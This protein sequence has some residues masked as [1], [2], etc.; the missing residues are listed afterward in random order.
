MRLM[1][2]SRMLA[3]LYMNNVT[4]EKQCPYYMEHQMHDNYLSKLIRWISHVVM[5]IMDIYTLSF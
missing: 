5:R 2:Y 1:R 3:S 4:P